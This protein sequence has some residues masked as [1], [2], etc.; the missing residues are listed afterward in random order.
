MC[1]LSG[2]CQPGEHGTL[3]TGRSQVGRPGGAHTTP[4]TQYQRPIPVPSLPITPG[5]TR[6]HHSH[7]GARREAQH[8]GPSMGTAGHEAHKVTHAH[9]ACHMHPASPR[10]WQAPVKAGRGVMSSGAA[11]HASSPCG[12]LMLMMMTGL[13]TWHAFLSSAWRAFPTICLTEWLR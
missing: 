7:W 2:V 8:A 4:H 11:V 3:G 13:H 1:D 6:S 10:W 12:V 5:H 9:L